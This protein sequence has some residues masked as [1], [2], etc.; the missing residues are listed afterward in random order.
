MRTNP[1]N[2]P[3]AIPIIAPVE[4]ADDVFCC[5]ALLL[6][7]LEVAL[8]LVVV[9]VEPGCVELPSIEGTNASK[10]D[11]NKLLGVLTL[12][13]FALDLQHASPPFDSQYVLMSCLFA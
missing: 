3:K 10:E 5:C 4:G 1:A 2:A 9:E 6:V 11:G 8:L 7:G 12:P 13:P